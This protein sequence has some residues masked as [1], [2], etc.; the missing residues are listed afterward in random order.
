MS[1]GR[2]PNDYE[3][4]RDGIAEATYNRTIIRDGIARIVASQL[5]T[6]QDSAM[7]SFAST[8]AI[9]EELLIGEI[10]L[11]LEHG[12]LEDE[13]RDHVRFLG[14]YVLKYGDRTK[15][16]GWNDIWG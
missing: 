10:S 11:E 14:L 3:L 5:H 9:D 8:G 12:R 6:G 15:V 16:E 1:Q 13:E 2:T 7:Y 4:L